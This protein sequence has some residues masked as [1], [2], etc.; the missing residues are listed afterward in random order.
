MTS[1]RKTVSLLMSVCFIAATASAAFA[2]TAEATAGKC[3]FQTL[4]FPP[5]AEKGQAIA[6]N[7]SGAI[8]GGFADSQGA[9]HGFLEF[10]GKVAT[11]MFP[12]SSITGASDISSNGIIVGGY[13]VANDPKQHAFMVRSGSFHEIILPGHPNADLRVTGVNA[14]GDVVGTFF[15]PNANNG[16][17]FLLQNGKLTILSFPE[18]TAGTQP[19][20]INDEGVVVGNYFILFVNSGPSFMWKDGVFSNINPPGNEGFIDTTKVSNSGVVVGSFQGAADQLSHGFALKNGTYTTINVPG[21]SNTSIVA[22]NKF[23]NI[24]VQA[25]IPGLGFSTNIQAKGFCA[26]AF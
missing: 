1:Q 15:D 16:F 12:G 20:S 6:L 2:Q 4:T 22:V 5:P 13:S 11:F 23:D 8:L 26:A 21:S 18:A 10:Q 25:V 19:N 17:G 14:N 9:G 7:D 24:L 3:S